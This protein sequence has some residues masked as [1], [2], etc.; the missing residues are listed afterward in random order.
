MKS[1][2]CKYTADFTLVATS[3][4]CT[5]CVLCICTVSIYFRFVC[6]I[7]CRAFAEAGTLKNHMR[8]HTGERPYACDICGKRFS[9]PSYLKK[10]LHSHKGESDHLTHVTTALLWTLSGRNV[11]FLLN[12]WLCNI[13]ALHLSFR[14]HDAA[15]DVV[16]PNIVNMLRLWGFSFCSCIIVS[17]LLPVHRLMKLGSFDTWTEMWGNV[18]VVHSWYFDAHSRLYCI[19]FWRPKE[20][21]GKQP[22]RTWMFEPWSVLYTGSCALKSW[23]ST[24]EHQIM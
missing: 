18:I 8:I 20:H 22:W 4:L 15:S 3:S 5:A 2:W 23:L 17:F 24:W 11:D 14:Q 12:F 16:T 21:F 10:H 13:V 6:E 1:A 19:L 7:C 9:M